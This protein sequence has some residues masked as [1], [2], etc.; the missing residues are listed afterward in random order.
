[1]TTI[2]AWA[3]SEQ[4]GKLEPFSYEPGPLKADEIEIEVTSC[5][6]CHSDMSMINNE[7]GTSKYP[8]VPGHEV[9]GKVTELGEQVKHLSVGQTVGIGWFAESCL[10]CSVCMGGDHN[11]CRSA[12]GMITPGHFGGFADRARAQAIWAVPLP[13]DVDPAKAGPL[14]CGGV[15][16]F[17][18]LMEYDLKPTDR[19]GV[20]GIGGLGHLALK[21]A[22]AWGCEVWA[23]TTSDSKTEEAKSMG[24][25]FVANTRDDSQLKKLNGKFDLILNTTDV[26]LPWDRYMAALSPKGKFITVGGLAE[27]PIEVGAFSLIGGQKLMGGSSV[28]SPA[29]IQKMLEFC[30]RHDIAPQTE[31]FPMDEVNEAMEHLKAGKARYRIVL[32]R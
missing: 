14:F 28:G 30:A 31:F 7:W 29:M 5:G 23:F 19:I 22:K 21:F 25:H 10:T 11:L 1:M 16:V 20:I 32:T 3:V 2:N 8:I 13:D 12:Q 24:A 26:S 15:T 6:I 17:T 18:P 27:K 4:G 9:I